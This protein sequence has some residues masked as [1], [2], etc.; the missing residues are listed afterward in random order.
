MTRE[1]RLQLLK[2]IEKDIYVC[3]LESTLTDDAKSCAIH[4]AIEELE[5]EKEACEDAVSRQEVIRLF[6]KNADAVRPYSQTWKE[7]KDLP[8]V[9]PT[10]RWIPCSERLPKEDGFYLVSTTDCII[11]M[12][13]NKGWISQNIGS[14]NWYVKAW[15]P[16]PKPYKAES[17]DK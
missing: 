14:C 7:V 1:E 13:F 10:Q 12:E 15:Q 6:A 16:L 9:T 17:E 2:Q 11:I 4:S 5:L 3:S 8:S